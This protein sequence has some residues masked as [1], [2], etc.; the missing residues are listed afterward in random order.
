[1]QFCLCVSQYEIRIMCTLHSLVDISA[2][3][4]PLFLTTRLTTGICKSTRWLNSTRNECD[5]LPFVNLDKNCDYRRSHQGCRC[6]NRRDWGSVQQSELISNTAALSAALTSSN[7]S[8]SSSF[9]PFSNQLQMSWWNRQH[10]KQR[11]KA[12]WGTGVTR[13][14]DM[15]KKNFR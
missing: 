13:I 4:P 5:S 3:C 14:L 15:E 1:M 8:F 12:F 7:P 11:W 9:H 6:K 10:L 2:R